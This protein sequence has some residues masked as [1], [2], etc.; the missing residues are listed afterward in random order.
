MANV[1]LGGVHGAAVHDSGGFVPISLA[2][3]ATII[4]AV[5]PMQHQTDVLLAQPWCL[6][7][8]PRWPVPSQG[9]KGPW[10]WGEGGLVPTRLTI[11]QCNVQASA[12]VV[13]H[14][15]HEAGKKSREHQ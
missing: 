12:D 1:W 8:G 13:F 5:R 9:R 14:A 7:W 6:G 4:V 11:H 2:V 3:L 10:P 15:A